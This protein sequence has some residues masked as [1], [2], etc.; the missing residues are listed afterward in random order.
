MTTD[1][2]N[3][4]ADGRIELPDVFG[5]VALFAIMDDGGTLCES[6][7]RDETNPV[8]PDDGSRDGWGVVGFDTTGNTDDGVQ[9]DHCSKVLQEPWDGAE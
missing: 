7:V 8:H 5:G 9:C 1:D 6:C 3:P 2:R 4:Y